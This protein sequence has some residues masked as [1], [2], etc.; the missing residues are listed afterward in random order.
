MYTNP[1]DYILTPEKYLSMNKNAGLYPIGTNRHNCS[2][3]IL[4]F[5]L[6]FLSYR[7]PVSGSSFC[8][9]MRKAMSVSPARR[10]PSLLVIDTIS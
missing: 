10:S 2:K 9:V 6:L 4:N 7:L 3:T 5:S 1:L 8:G